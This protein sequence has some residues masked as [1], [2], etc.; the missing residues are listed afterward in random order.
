MHVMGYLEKSITYGVATYIA[1]CR[2]LESKLNLQLVKVIARQL[3]QLSL[4]LDRAKSVVPQPSVHVALVWLRDRQN[5]LI[6]KSWPV[7]CKPIT[8]KIFIMITE[9]GSDIPN[10]FRK[11]VERRNRDSE[12]STPTFIFEWALVVSCTIKP[13]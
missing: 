12:R 3:V 5:C 10:T 8:K 9:L 6:V 4:Q 2:F 1:S 7:T 11:S 13:A